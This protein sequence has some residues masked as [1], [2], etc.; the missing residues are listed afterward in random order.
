MICSKS[1]FSGNAVIVIFN[2]LASTSIHL[3]FVILPLFALAN[4]ANSSAKL[5]YKGL[6]LTLSLNSI[7]SQ[8]L[9]E[10]EGTVTFTPFT[11][12]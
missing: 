4:S 6:S 11:M 2:F 3:V 8:T 12:K 1:S 9:T 7:T 10:I 5:L